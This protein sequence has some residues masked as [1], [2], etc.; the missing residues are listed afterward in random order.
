MTTF[1]P[2]RAQSQA[3]PAV[4]WQICSQVHC[5]TG[6]QQQ[7]KKAKQNQSCKK[8]M[9]HQKKK[10]I[11]EQTRGALIFIAACLISF[12][13]LGIWFVCFRH[14]KHCGL[15]LIRDLQPVPSGAGMGSLLSC[16]RGFLLESQTWLIPNLGFWKTQ[17]GDG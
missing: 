8:P 13:Y 3:H 15:W 7:Q 12:I 17:H 16:P 2:H 1:A 10:K 14:N 11:P 5:S 4:H 6:K 9:S